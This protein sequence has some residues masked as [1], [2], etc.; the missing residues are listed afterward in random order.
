VCYCLKLA[1]GSGKTTIMARLIAWSVLNKGDCFGRGMNT[2]RQSIYLIAPKFDLF[3]S[4]CQCENCGRT[5]HDFGS[6]VS[7]VINEDRHRGAIGTENT[8]S[9]EVLFEH[10]W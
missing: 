7:F 2:K 4:G 8:P 3:R 10:D 5:R 6:D 1:T 9:V